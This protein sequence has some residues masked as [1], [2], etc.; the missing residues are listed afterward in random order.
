MVTVGAIDQWFAWYLNPR[1]VA[2]NLKTLSIKLVQN[3]AGSE[4][5]IVLVKGVGHASNR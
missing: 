3:S 2:H 4:E 5:T 1:L